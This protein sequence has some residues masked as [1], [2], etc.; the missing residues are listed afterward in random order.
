MALIG[1]SP[2]SKEL[3]DAERGRMM[4]AIARDSAEVVRRHTDAQGFNYQTSSNIT[5]A[6]N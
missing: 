5:M 2:A 1:M 6:K 4:A 3:S